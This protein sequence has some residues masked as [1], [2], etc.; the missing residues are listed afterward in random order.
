MGGLPSGWEKLWRDRTL[1]ASRKDQVM[2]PAT[3]NS[4]VNYTW[5]S[6]DSLC[7]QFLQLKIWELKVIINWILLQI[8]PHFI[9]TGWLNL[10]HLVLHRTTEGFRG[11]QVASEL[12]SCSRYVSISPRIYHDNPVSIYMTHFTLIQ[13]ELGILLRILADRQHFG[14]CAKDILMNYFQMKE[15]LKAKCAFL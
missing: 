4:L 10:D 6:T 15:K 3:G 8:W 2:T 11:H 9:L 12:C 1:Q 7:L 13:R 5:P 14:T